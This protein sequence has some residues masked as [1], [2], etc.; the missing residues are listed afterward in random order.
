VNDIKF[1]ICYR[2]NILFQEFVRVTLL[3]LKK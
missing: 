3:V 2:Q 1:L